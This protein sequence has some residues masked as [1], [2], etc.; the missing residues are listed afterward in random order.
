[1]AS[2][3]NTPDENSIRAKVSIFARLVPAFS[4]TVPPLGAALS[5]FLVFRVLEAMRN[6]ETAGVAAVGR[7]LHEA[8][9]AVLIALYLAI[10]VGFAGIVV[11]VIR[12]V[13][14]TKTVAPST[15]FFFIGGVLG[16]IPVVLLW[17][18]E[19][20]LIQVIAH[21]EN[22]AYVVSTVRLLLTMTLVAAPIGALLLLAGSV[23]P[24]A[25]DSKRRWGPLIALLVIEF[26]VIAAVIAF[27]VRTSWFYQVSQTDTMLNLRKDRGSA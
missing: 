19:S 21:H 5:A 4:Y 27:Q 2:P 11:A 13:L 20:V 17:E 18:A 6:A 25:S 8:N 9:L 3:I 16:L 23:W 24:L 15:W 10:V 26:L 14:G 22:M 1:M 12:L 7:G